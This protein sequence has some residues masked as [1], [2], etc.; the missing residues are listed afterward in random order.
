V[1]I[2]AFTYGITDGH[3][4]SVYPLIIL[5]V[6]GPRHYTEI[7]IWKSLSHFVSKIIWKNFMSSNCFFFFKILYIPSAI[8]LVWC[9]LDKMINMIMLMIYNELIMINHPIGSSFVCGF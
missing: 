7:L 5:T 6:N 9:Y 2:L 1:D 3:V 8:W 4:M